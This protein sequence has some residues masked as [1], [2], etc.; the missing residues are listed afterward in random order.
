[1]ANIIS[2]RSRRVKCDEQKPSCA[3]CIRAG[4]ECKGYPPAA[5][6]SQLHNGELSLNIPIK[7]YS[8]P[9][10][11][12]G[13]RTDRQL[14]HFY[15]SDAAGNLSDFYHRELWTRIILQRCHDQSI[16]RNAVVTLSSLYLDYVR[17]ENYYADIG[18]SAPAKSLEQ[19][20]KCH[21]QLM[22]HLSSP[23]ASLEIGLICSL[24]FHAFETI[25][26][27]QQ[28][29]IFHLDQGIL[30]LKRYQAERNYPLVPASEE[31]CTHLTAQ[32][33][34]LDVRASRCDPTRVPLLNLVSPAEISGTVS[35]VPDVFFSP[36]HAEAVYLKLENWS[37]HR[38]RTQGAESIENMPLQ[39]I[40]ENKVFAGELKKYCDNIE[41]L[42]YYCRSQDPSWTSHALMLQISSRVCYTAFQNTP[43]PD[44]SLPRQN[45][46]E[47][48]ESLK[49]IVSDM[50]CLLSSFKEPYQFADSRYF[51]LSS[52][53]IMILTFVIIKTTNR[54]TLDKSLSLLE[55]NRLPSREGLADSEAMGYVFQ[56]LRSQLLKE[57][58]RGDDNQYFDTT[59]E[60]LG[61]NI[62]TRPRTFYEMFVNMKSEEAG[63]EQQ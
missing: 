5:K 15:C 10:K 52:N 55:H 39:T 18:W 51:T 45:R 40:Y 16:I 29:S 19:I 20:T 36:T 59:M 7:A 44:P 13:S 2:S 25:L 30:L 42:V 31:L 41:K 48:E 49:E 27:N 58:I 14:L 43:S 8:I 32:F 21:R 61:A 38:K 11:V 24:F 62:L 35:L 3:R 23:N 17:G 6:N 53:L 47:L 22:T 46:E 1:V 50:D 26:G 54:D 33:S 37:E 4:R 60:Q 63:N 34:R 56:K 28:Q 12:P 57:H 9:F